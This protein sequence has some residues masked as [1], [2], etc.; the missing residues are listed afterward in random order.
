MKLK[1]TE[2]LKSIWIAPNLHFEERQKQNSLENYLKKYRKK[3][4]VGK[5]WYITKD[6]QELTPTEYACSHKESD[7]IPAQWHGKDLLPQK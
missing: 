1:D 7:D 4:G 3:N 6:T 2:K 5:H